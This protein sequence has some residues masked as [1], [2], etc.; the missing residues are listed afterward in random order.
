MNARYYIETPFGGIYLVNFGGW[1][2]RWALDR[3]KTVPGYWLFDVRWAWFCVQVH[4]DHKYFKEA[5][6]FV[7]RFSDIPAPAG[8]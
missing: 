2:L 8:I 7:D 4:P 6:D 5:F 1:E 3:M